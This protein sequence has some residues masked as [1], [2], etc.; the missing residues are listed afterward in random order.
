MRLRV[1]NS[2][3]SPDWLGLDADLQHGVDARDCD[4]CRKETVESYRDHY[5][6]F[7][8]DVVLELLR[9]RGDRPN[10]CR[11]NKTHEVAPPH[12]PLRIRLL[13]YRKPSTYR[14]GS[15]R[16]LATPGSGGSGPMSEVGQKRK[17]RP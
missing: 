5:V 13:E 10:R 15:E 16:E 7:V 4:G 2:C 17:S 12:V 6:P 11:T 14:P 8:V 3:C 9:V 1:S